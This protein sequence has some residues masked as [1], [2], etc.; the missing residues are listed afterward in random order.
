[1]LSCAIAMR[2][3]ASTG[4]KQSRYDKADK[5]M[6]MTITLPLTEP[7]GVPTLRF[8]RKPHNLIQGIAAVRL[9][10]PIRAWRAFVDGLF[11]PVDWIGGFDLSG[12]HVGPHGFTAQ[13]CRQ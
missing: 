2:G 11:F 1:M 10:T 4:I 13:D 9:A 6:A 7:M 3:R 5:R 8:W 12:Y